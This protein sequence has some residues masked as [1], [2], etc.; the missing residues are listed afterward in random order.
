MQLGSEDALS[1]SG[2]DITPL[3]TAATSGNSN[4]D[5]IAFL[6]KEVSR[7]RTQ[8]EI[9]KISESFPNEISIRKDKDHKIHQ[10][11]LKTQLNSIETNDGNCNC[12]SAAAG[13]TVMPSVNEN[14]R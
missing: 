7:W 6:E 4:E 14:K 8:C 1:A 9:A 13:I 12:S 11:F 2:S 10:Q 3:H 5:R